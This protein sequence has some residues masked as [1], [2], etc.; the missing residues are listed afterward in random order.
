M[1]NAEDGRREGNESGNGR[2]DEDGAERGGGGREGEILMV[3]REMDR[4]EIEMGTK[5]IQN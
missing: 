2:E 3:I 1:L 4:N 5:K